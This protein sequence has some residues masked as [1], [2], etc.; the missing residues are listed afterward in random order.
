VMANLVAGVFAAHLTVTAFT[1]IRPQSR[2]V[3]IGLLLIGV[4]LT[5]IMFYGAFEKLALPVGQRGD[6]PIQVRFMT[7]IIAL[8]ATIGDVRVLV[9]GALRGSRRIARHMWRMCWALF[10]AAGS[11]FAQVHDN[12]SGALRSPLVILLPVLIVFVAM[13]YWFWRLRRR[14]KPFVFPTLSNTVEARSS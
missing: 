1:T 11:F 8:L 14:S 5:A 7:A 3:E 4:A 9:G 13:G 12:L 10:I 2:R 6:V